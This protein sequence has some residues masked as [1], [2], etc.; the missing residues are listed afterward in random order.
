MRIINSMLAPVI[1]L[2]RY[3]DAT[4]EIAKIKRVDSSLQDI[5]IQNARV[6]E[7]RNALL[8][9]LKKGGSV[10]EVGVAAGGYS[11]Q[12][13]KI[14]QPDTLYLIDYWAKNKEAH[15]ITPA[16]VIRGL[17]GSGEQTW[18]VVKEKFKPEISSGN[19][20][21]HRGY[22]WDM[23]AKLPDH[24]LDWLYLDAAHDYS[25][26]VKDLEVA[27][28]KVKPEG[29]IAGHDYVRWG[30]FGYKCGVVEAVNE[31]CIK[32]GY[33]ILYL[34]METKIPASFA[35]RKIPKV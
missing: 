29:I 24:S 21:L 7:N 11:E 27:R 4:K 10:A 14:C 6:L 23:L 19:V 33:E 20:V 16:S 22:S 17:L 18:D 26:V 8:S 31:F 32:Y 25:S 12:I 5:H 15:G 34:T 28:V 9:R 1:V 2:K 3:R 13:L 35:I 30:K